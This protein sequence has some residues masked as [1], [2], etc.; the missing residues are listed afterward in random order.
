[1]SQ[2]LK[3]QP[4]S[5]RQ[6]TGGSFNNAEEI[7][8]LVNSRHQDN[9]TD[10]PFNPQNGTQASESSKVKKI[11]I[12]LTFWERFWKNCKRN[13]PMKQNFRILL[14]PKQ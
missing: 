2:N 1:M 14:T 3:K 13:L 4:N 10:M 6:Q 8:E 7:D 9:E 11:V 12:Y 5:G